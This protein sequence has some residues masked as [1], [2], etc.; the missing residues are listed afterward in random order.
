MTNGKL[1]KAAATIDRFA[2][3]LA[4]LGASVPRSAELEADILLVRM[5]LEEAVRAS[6][7]HPSGSF[8]SLSRIAAAL[9]VKL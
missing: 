2:D 9:G 6:G 1:D 3:A 7:V 4:A 5:V 8:V